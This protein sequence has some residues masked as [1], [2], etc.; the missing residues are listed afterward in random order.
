MPNRFSLLGIPL[1]GFV[2]L[3][4]LV[5]GCVLIGSVTRGTESAS[6]LTAEGPLVGP[7]VP[8]AEEV[9]VL[10]RGRPVISASREAERRPTS[11]TA[12]AQIADLVPEGYRPLV[13][14]TAARHHLD[15]RLLAAV[16]KL[17][18]HFDPTT[19][20]THGE[21]GLMQI[22]ADTGE[23]LAHLAKMDEYDLRDDATSL[24]LGALY[25]EVLVREYG[26]VEQALAAYNGGPRAAAGWE[27]N[28][29][30]ER[31]LQYYRRG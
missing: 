28:V 29:Y 13:L 18:S 4:G 16:I 30:V 1:R 11:V 27:T 2:L 5:L 26:S 14:S 21:V 20:G 31:V 8:A 17:E 15:P 24:D 6:P 3:L 12:E 7:P 22:M 10:E 9:V 19:V 25:L 23:W